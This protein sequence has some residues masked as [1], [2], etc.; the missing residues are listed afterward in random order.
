MISMHVVDPTRHAM[1]V[2]CLLC[3][4]WH[5]VSLPRAHNVQFYNL[6][7]MKTRSQMLAS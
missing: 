2:M 6:S 5:C 7:V 1:C 3:M 4:V